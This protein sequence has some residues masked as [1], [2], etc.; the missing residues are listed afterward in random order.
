M[1]SIDEVIEVFQKHGQKV[2]PQRREILKIL[3]NNKDHPK[4]EEIYRILKNRMP[5]VTLATVYNTLN[6][7]RDL[8]MIEPIGVI[9]DDSV[10]YDP[11]TE[12][13][14]HLCCLRC[15]HIMDVEKKEL[16]VNFTQNEIS[17]FQIVK[18]M[19]TY[20]GYCPECQKML[21]TI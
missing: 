14:D 2:T 9:G 7:L 1:K 8:G 15:K 19:V 10:H 11:T 13:H 12:A 17:G 21:K 4:A 6:V 3:V 16:E 5:D 18:R 20:Y